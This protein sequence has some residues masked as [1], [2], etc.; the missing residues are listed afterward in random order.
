MINGVL[1]VT[2]YEDPSIGKPILER[3]KERLAE[4]KSID[5]IFNILR[6]HMTFFNYEIL[7][8]LIVTIGSKEDKRM[9]KVYLCDFGYFCR[10]RVFEVPEKAMGQQHFHVKI[11]KAFKSALLSECMSESQSSSEKICVPDLCISPENAKHIQR[12]L[13]LVLKLKI[14]SLYLDSVSAGS[15][16]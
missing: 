10:R 3:E 16:T 6:P 9:L 15:T 1:A 5:T 8:F 4:A 7:E 13:A 14:S 11:T 2:E 12:K